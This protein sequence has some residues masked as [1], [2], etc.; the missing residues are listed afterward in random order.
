MAEIACSV[1]VKKVSSPFLL[2]PPS[3]VLAGELELL[4]RGGFHLLEELCFT[5]VGFLVLFWGWFFLFVFYICSVTVILQK[6]KAVYSPRQKLYLQI[7]VALLR[8]DSAA[9]AK[10]AAADL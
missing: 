10:L 3:T 5:T 7:Y 6:I 2:C 4:Q 9:S 8:R 1:A